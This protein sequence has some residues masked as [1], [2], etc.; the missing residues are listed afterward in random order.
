MKKTCIGVGLVSLMLIS[1]LGA[2]ILMLATFLKPS[3]LIAAVSSVITLLGLGFALY[4]YKKNSDYQVDQD[5]VKEVHHYID[6]IQKNLGDGTVLERQIDPHMLSWKLYKLRMSLDSLDHTFDKIQCETQIQSVKSRVYVCLTHVVLEYLSRIF[7]SS[8]VHESQKQEIA[9]KVDR[10]TQQ[11]PEDLGYQP[12]AFTTTKHI[13][14]K[15]DEMN[16]SY[17]F[18]YFKLDQNGQ[19]IIESIECLLATLYKYTPYTYDAICQTTPLIMAIY[20]DL[21]QQQNP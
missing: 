14:S 20:E 3:D 2:A 16:I 13:Y 12:D 5:Y 18:D 17:I 11:L 10:Y 21:Q 4:Q 8:L 9:S 7:V 6:S 19:V 15:I 1:Q